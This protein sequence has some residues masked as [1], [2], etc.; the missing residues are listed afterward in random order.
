MEIYLYVFS[1]K[2]TI[3]RRCYMYLLTNKAY[4][5]EKMVNY[6]KN[7]MDFIEEV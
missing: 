7:I 1:H 4:K 6:D 5:G 2:M 3:V